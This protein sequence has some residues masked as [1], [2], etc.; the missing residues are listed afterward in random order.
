MFRQPTRSPVLLTQLS[1]FQREGLLLVAATTIRV[2]SWLLPRTGMSLGSCCL[3]SLLP[4]MLYW[5]T[6]QLRIMQDTWATS[7][8]RVLAQAK[9]LQVYIT[10][11]LLLQHFSSSMST[12]PKATNP[13]PTKLMLSLIRRTCSNLLRCTNLQPM[14]RCLL[15]LPCI[16]QGPFTSARLTKMPITRLTPSLTSAWLAQRISY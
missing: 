5:P 8:R 11:H 10:F 7:L 14:P 9:L 6:I 4:I 13:V 15:R 12:L 3:V 1:Q 2:P 16:A